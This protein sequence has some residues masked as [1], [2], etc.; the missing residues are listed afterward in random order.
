MTVVFQELEGSP[1]ETFNSDGIV[2]KRT[3]LV[4]WADRYEFLK[5]L[6]G[7]GGTFGTGA[8]KHYPDLDKV[9]AVAVTFEAH[10]SDVIAQ[11]LTDVQDDL[12]GYATYAKATV[13]Y[14]DFVGP[15]PESGTWGEYRQDFGGE[16]ITLPDGFVRWESDESI[17]VPEDAMPTAR[18]PIIEHHLTWHRVVTPPWAQIRKTIGCV[19]LNVLGADQF[20]GDPEEWNKFGLVGA[21]AETVL[22]EG[23][24]ASK[25]FTVLDDLLNPQNFWQLGYHFREKE[26]RIFMYIPG[27]GED[28]THIGWNHVFRSL[29]FGDPGWDKLVD[30]VGS[31]MY[32]KASFT[33]L[34]QFISQPDE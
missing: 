28:D 17:P 34:F 33:G 7:T 12:Q 24:T 23:C 5:E 29:P 18:V 15:S 11:E 21:N 3:F 1:T 31:Y 14:K 2:C 26:A 30:G 22:F 13:D 20:P 16:Y 27:V 32:K 6:L 25:E 19:N 9:L 8:V 4:N 10:G